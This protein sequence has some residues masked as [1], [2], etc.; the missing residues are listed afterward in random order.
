MF[1]MSLGSSMF[2]FVECKKAATSESTINTTGK[3]VGK[4]DLDSSER[5]DKRFYQRTKRRG[6]LSRHN[7]KSP[8]EWKTRMLGKRKLKQLEQ[9]WIV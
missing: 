8:N 7:Y 2:T 6:I 9:D 4:K 5:F 1:F 3:G